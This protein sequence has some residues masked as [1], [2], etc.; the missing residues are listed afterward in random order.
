MGSWS[1]TYGYAE[2]GNQYVNPT[3]SSV[4]PISPFAPTATSSFDARNRLN[5]NNSAYDPS[6]N[7]NQTALGGYTFSYDAEGS[8]TPPSDRRSAPPIVGRSA[9]RLPLAPSPACSRRTVDRL[10]DGTD[11]R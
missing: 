2:P 8:G 9:P 6:G 1:R 5:L 11:I 3:D 4:Y 7:G 10:P